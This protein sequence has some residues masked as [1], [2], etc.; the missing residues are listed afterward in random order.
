MRPLNVCQVAAELTPFAKTG[1][2]GDVVAGLSRFLS[3]DGH[4]VRIFLPF[5]RQISQRQETFVPVDFLQD[6]PLSFGHRYFTF[7]ARTAKL[8]GS[9]VDVYFIDC[10]ALYDHEGIFH[11]D[12]ADWLRFAVLTR[13]AFECCQRMSWGPDVI[14]SHDW[15]TGLAPAFLK[16]LYTWD[17]LFDHT[18][19]VLT[20]HN[21]AFQGIAPGGA[22]GDLGLASHT[23][24]LDGGDLA[25]G[26]LNF[27][28]TGLLH[29]DAITAVSRTYA[30]EIQ[31]PEHGFG[32]DWLLRAR[33]NRLVGIVNGVDYR[34]WDTGT[35]PHLFYL[36]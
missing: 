22:V 7:S 6:V 14:H 29:A 11:G 24:W 34:D 13:A 12:W 35:D 21:M 23:H 1:G 20:I 31:T 19:T 10:P 4:D 5:Y 25:A 28:K 32:L 9:D 30:R 17:R 16:T 27:L 36:Y 15:H 33:S 26:R 2:L 18:R 3:R 8:P